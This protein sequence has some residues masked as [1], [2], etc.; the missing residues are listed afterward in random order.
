[1]ATRFWTILTALVVLSSITFPTIA[2]ARWS[3]AN[4]GVKG[5]SVGAGRPVSRVFAFQGHRAPPAVQRIGSGIVGESFGRRQFKT[6]GDPSCGNCV[7]EP[8]STNR[9]YPYFR[10]ATVHSNYNITYDPGVTTRSNFVHLGQ[11]YHPCGM[12]NPN[13]MGGVLQ[14]ALRG[15]L[16]NSNTQ[17]CTEQASKTQPCGMSNPNPTSAIA[18]IQ[19]VLGNS[20]N[21]PCPEQAS[22]DQPCGMS[23]PNPAGSA[24]GAIQ[25]ILSNASNQP[26]PQSVVGT[27]LGD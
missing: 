18:A 7:T 26:C 22:K 5:L 10:N 15:V 1:M 8:N 17:P 3:F 12:S 6:L 13:P 27:I 4:F 23:N 14:G 16:G 21:Q 24:I 19:G 9:N 20:S 11:Q 25:G 2:A